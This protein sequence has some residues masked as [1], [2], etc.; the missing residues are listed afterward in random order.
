VHISDD[1]KRGV[2]EYLQF[3][4]RNVVV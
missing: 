2:E 3:A 1:Y 4:Q